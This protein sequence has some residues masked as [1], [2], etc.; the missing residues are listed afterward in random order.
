MI[1]TAV[2][3]M[4]IA[5]ASLAV[6]GPATPASADSNCQVGKICAWRHANFTGD[7]QTEGGINLECIGITLSG[8]AR[9]AKNE[10]LD[11]V[12]VF[13]TGTRCDGVPTAALLP[14]GGSNA[15]FSPSFSFLVSAA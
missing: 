6:I 4:T 14:V 15:S 5:A 7:K 3:A 8:G 2:A 10:S 13:N 9:S 11:R 12:I 1:R